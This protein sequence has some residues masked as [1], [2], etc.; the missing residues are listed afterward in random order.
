MKADLQE[1]NEQK[2]DPHHHQNAV[3][4][5]HHL[6]GYLILPAIV[7]P[8]NLFPQG[9]TTPQIMQRRVQ[10]VSAEMAV[11]QQAEAHREEIFHKVA[12]ADVH[13]EEVIQQVEEVRFADHPRQ[14]RNST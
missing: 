3:V 13:R 10:A 6:R 7:G 11:G 9:E 12:E 5:K 1:K 4:L 8:G 2:L 14:T